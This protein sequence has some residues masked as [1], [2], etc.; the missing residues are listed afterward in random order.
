MS[1]IENYIE[2][3][4]GKKEKVLSV[5]LT[6]GFPEVSGFENLALDVLNAGADL[7]E[8]GIPFSDPLADGPIIQTSS[9]TALLNGV[10]PGLALEYCKKIRAKTE[11]PLIVMTYANILQHYGVKKF[12]E[13]AY[14]SGVNGVIIPDLS[15]DE[16]ENFVPAEKNGMEVI[17]LIA[18]PTT[19]ERIVSI[20]NKS[21]GFTYYVSI[22]GTTGVRSDFE[23]ETLESL[24]KVRNNTKKKLLVGFGISKPADVKLFSPYSDGVIVGSAVIKKL[25]ECKPGSYDEVLKY[26]S[27]MKEA[28][29]G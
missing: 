16:Y 12:F 7:L 13:D 19:N 15:V 18:L 10:T 26:V 24:K 4:N 22:T 1:F 21:E 17:L 29:K 8:I 11:K 27:S 20:D 28:C 2:S 9:H 14:A 6:A 5:Y 25:I 23:N 3:V